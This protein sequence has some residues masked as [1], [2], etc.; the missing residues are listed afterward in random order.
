M[1]LV[2]SLTNSLFIC[3]AFAITPAQA[4]PIKL[5]T[6]DG[7]ILHGQYTTPRKLTEKHPA[8][9]LIHQGGSDHSEWNFMLPSLLSKNYVVL[10]YDVRGH[11]KS[12]KVA[13][14]GQLFNDPTLAPKG[15]AAAIKYVKKKKHVDG[16]RI[17]VVGASIGGNLAAVAI[18]NMG[19]KTAVC[20]SGKTSAVFNLAGKKEL[21]LQSVYYISSNENRGKRAAWAQE[22]HKLTK[23]PRK[24]TIIKSSDG[25]GVEIFKDEPNVEY[26]ILQWLDETL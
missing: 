19:V 24:I 26:Q 13:N 17:A 9:I 25:H 18:A 5:V 23:E 4:K 20:I 3:L 10:A 8:V 15:L 2:K 22:L 14:M 21:A 6:T 1:N 11:G 7:V 12:D 16:T